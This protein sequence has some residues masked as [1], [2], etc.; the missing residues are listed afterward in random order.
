[1]SKAESSASITCSSLPS[2]ASTVRRSELPIKFRPDCGGRAGDNE[3]C[4]SCFLESRNNSVTSKM[5]S[6]YLSKGLLFYFGGFVCLSVPCLSL[7]WNLQ[8][9]LYAKDVETI[10]RELKHVH[11]HVSRN[12]QDS[13]TKLNP[14]SDGTPAP[15]CFRAMVLNPPHAVTL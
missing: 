12:S 8:V 1:M 6:A 5:T 2:Q 7:V 11:D 14:G 4:G 15:S 13:K 3:A 10:I 9:T